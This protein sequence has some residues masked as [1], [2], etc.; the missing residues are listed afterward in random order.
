MFLF[1]ATIFIAELIIAGTLIVNILKAD[2]AVK[3]LNSELVGQKPQIK[4]IL[5][6][7]REGIHEVKEKQSYFFDLIKKKREQY[8]INSL[9]LILTYLLLHFIKSR[10]KKASAICNGILLIKDVWDSV[11]A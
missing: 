9:K 6:G 2:K 7:I 11:S 1:I 4:A 5:S 3:A 10:Y 8:L